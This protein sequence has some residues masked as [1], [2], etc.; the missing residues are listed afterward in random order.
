M[1]PPTRL[2]FLPLIH[3][4]TDDGL[5]SQSA[6]SL[7]PGVALLISYRLALPITTSTC[8]SVYLPS[9]SLTI[10]IAYYNTS[11]CKPISYLHFLHLL[12][13]LSQIPQRYLALAA[14]CPQDDWFLGAVHVHV[15]HFDPLHSL[16]GPQVD[17]RDDEPVAVGQHHQGLE[18]PHQVLECVQCTWVHNGV[19][20]I[21]HALILLGCS[22]ES[23]LNQIP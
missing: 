7:T 16:E 18:V 23:T 1:V 3:R 20:Q 21:S 8:S 9:V 2:L 22:L 12:H 10:S 14:Q 6:C 15:L 17:V 11:L 13:H 19:A 5:V 4:G